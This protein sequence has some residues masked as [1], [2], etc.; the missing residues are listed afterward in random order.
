M[1]SF[2]GARGIAN[3]VLYEGYLLY[4][5]TASAAK[6][7]MRWQFGV[8]VPKAYEAAGT[9]EH[10]EQQT[11]VLFDVTASTR[12]DVLLRFLHVEARAVEALRGT[13]FE[14]VAELRVDGNLHLSFDETVEREVALRLDPAAGD[15]AAV[16]VEFDAA[17]T[18]EEVYDAGGALAGRIVRQRWA[19]TGTLDASVSPVA[20][21][22]GLRRLRVR[23]ENH[24]DIVA[25]S[26]R[27]AVLRT[28][29]ISAH[30][31]LG[32]EEGAF[33]SPVDPPE[34]A[35]EATGTLQNRHTWPVLMGDATLDPQ[36]S[37]VALSSPIVLADF[38]EVAKKTDADAFDSTEIDELLTLSVLSLSDAERAE[39]RATDPRARAIID[40]AER[41]GAADIARLH[42]GDLTTQ[43]E[44]RFTDPRTRTLVD[45]NGPFSELDFQR[46]QAGDIEPF[47]ALPPKSVVVGGVSL[48]KGSAV[49]LSPKR[50][51]DA[52]DIFLAGKRATVR[53]I[54]QDFE[55]KI[56]VAVTVD[57]DPA[58]ELHE[59]YGRSFFF[60][61]DEVEPVEAPA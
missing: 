60:E 12:I 46:L 28:A 53:A 15:A 21:N 16:P 5:Y 43:P 54:H 1:S 8:V 49:R 11:E 55:D 40:R 25:T 23:L 10:G 32:I 47:E 56:Y 6:N 52:W 19:L 18:F 2:E 4:P 30:T 22:P 34:Y 13:A 31:L 41:F 3:A 58:T 7:K 61:P 14:P 17:R 38:P 27:G 9:G 50:R 39:A 59:W 51:A 20:G 37:P 26:E 48:E 44:T 36:R 57:D 42:D 24:S 45:L 33:L 35:I 29:F